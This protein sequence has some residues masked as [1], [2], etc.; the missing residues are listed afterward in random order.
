ML[1]SDPRKLLIAQIGYEPA[2]HQRYRAI[3]IY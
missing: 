2:A 1:S 3:A